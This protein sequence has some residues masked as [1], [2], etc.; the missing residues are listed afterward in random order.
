MKTTITLR[1]SF[2]YLA[3][4]SAALFIVL[5]F[6]LYQ[7]SRS[8]A[9]LTAAHAARYQSY[10][11]ADELRQSSD[12]LTRLARTYVVTG[13]SKYE[14]QY[15]DILDIRNG[16]KPRPEHYERIYWDFVAAGTSKPSADG[17]T[18]ALDELMKKAGFTDEEFAK[19]KEAQANS[20]ALVKSE[21]I[22]M[23]AVKGL[24]DDGSGK[25]TRKGE[26][27]L[28]LARKLMHDENYHKNKASIMKPVNQFLEL[29]DARTGN[30]VLAAEQ[31]NQSRYLIVV[32]LQLLSIVIILGALFVVYRALMKLL[33]NEPRVAA[34]LANQI[35]AGDLTTSIEVAADDKASLMFAMKTMRDNLAAIVGQV[36]VGT[37]TI[38]SASGQIASGNMDLASRTEA[39]AGAVEETA[40]S[41]E[42]LTGT[43]KQNADNARQANQLAVSASEVAVKGG[44]VVSE[45]VG[46][47]TS[48]NQSSRQI[49][50]IIAVIDGIAFQTNILALNAAVEAAR[51]GEQGRG[52]AVVASEVRNLAQ[53]SASAAKEIKALIDNSVEQ[54]ST[55]SKLVDQ[56]GATM[57]EIVDSVKR[58]TDIMGEITS[59]SVEQTSGIEQINEAINHMDEATQQNA[60]LVE[61]LATSAQSMQ[62]QAANLAQVVSV[63]RLHGGV[64]AQ[65][66]S[67]SVHQ[68]ARPAPK[69]LRAKAPARLAHA[70]SDDWE[71]F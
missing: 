48:I 8:Q 52:F 25:F 18:V 19:L 40:S 43:V 14:Q 20:D 44:A 49:V 66:V 58:V 22:A 70:G 62:E 57:A 39:Q 27:D 26:P 63:F 32:A 37:D 53:R 11:L 10:L 50:D 12:D 3:L 45:V 42:E 47:M 30:A 69:A 46:T 61:E 29:L 16:K 34:T 71:Q 51:A 6:A 15:M 60:T 23:N 59:A 31:S 7:I 24:F 65:P 9:Q 33:G 4:F 13:D 5:L 64:Q 67:A 41:M 2:S 38:A 1:K 55:G 54:I 21:V 36:R 68:L 28:E 35:A 17:Q 56:A